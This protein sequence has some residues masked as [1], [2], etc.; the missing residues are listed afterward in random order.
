M[1]A[2]ENKQLLQKI[3][4]ELGKGNSRPFV[5]SMA[6]DFNWTITGTTKWSRKF[7]GKETVLTELFGALRTK[8][9]VPITTIAQRFIADEDYV[10]VEARGKN[11]TTDGKPYNNAYCFVFRL[12]G[13]K[14]QEV[15]E[16]L[17]TEMVTSALG[18]VP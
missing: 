11:T 10:A 7:A 14:L 1:S 2:A 15:T 16:Y 6:D 3:F 8:L 12:S 13:G 18:D 9:N 5:E 4:A 17:D